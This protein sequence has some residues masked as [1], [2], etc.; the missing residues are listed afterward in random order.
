M[1]RLPTDRELNGG[2][3]GYGIGNIISAFFGCPPT[4]TFSQNVGIVVG[5]IEPKHGVVGILVDFNII[6]RL[7][8][9]TCRAGVV[10]VRPVPKISGRGVGFHKDKLA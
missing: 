10:N 9:C 2:I 6:A 4:A 7:P 3:I 8:G 1:D 5:I